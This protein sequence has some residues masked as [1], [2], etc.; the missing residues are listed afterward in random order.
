[1]AKIKAAEELARSRKPSGRI[2]KDDI[3]NAKEAMKLYGVKKAR[4]RKPSGRLTSD[5]IKRAMKKASPGGG[6]TRRS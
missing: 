5:D 6:R 2:N 4:D 1:M 3:N